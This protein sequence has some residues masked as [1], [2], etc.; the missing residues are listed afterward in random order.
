MHFQYPVVMI[1]DSEV[2]GGVGTGASAAVGSMSAIEQLEV[3]YA[4]PFV[5]LRSVPLPPGAMAFL[6]DPL[7]MVLLLYPTL[8]V[9]GMTG[10]AVAR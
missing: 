10:S 9:A 7:R 3:G 2:V 8:I 6:G 4:Y 5:A 1:T